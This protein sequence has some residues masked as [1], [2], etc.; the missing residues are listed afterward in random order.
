MEIAYQR[1]GFVKERLDERSVRITLLSQ[2][3][4]WLASGSMSWM[5]GLAQ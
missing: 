1:H 3:T 4:V 2:L 5:P